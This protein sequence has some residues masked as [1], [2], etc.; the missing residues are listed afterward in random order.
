[1]IPRSLQTKERRG[2]NGMGKKKKKWN[3]K[4]FHHFK[5]VFTFDQTHR[6]WLFHTSDSILETPAL[7][8][9]EKLSISGSNLPLGNPAIHLNRLQK[10]E[11][12]CS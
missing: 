8:C 12:S 9:F 4:G 3:G 1:M 5:L 2:E 10:S 6:R 7:L 11:L